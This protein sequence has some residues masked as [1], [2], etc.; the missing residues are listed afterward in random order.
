MQFQSCCLIDFSNIFQASCSSFISNEATSSHSP[1]SDRGHGS[2]IGYP[3]SVQDFSDMYSTVDKS[4][5]SSAPPLV[6]EFI[7]PVN[8]MMEELYAKV[9][10]TSNRNVVEEWPGARPKHSLTGG[11]QTKRHSWASNHKVS[12]SDSENA[13]ERSANDE[14]EMGNEPLHSSPKW[15]NHLNSGNPD[16][17][18][19]GGDG[20]ADRRS[21][22]SESYFQG[23]KFANSIANDLVTPAESPYCTYE[24]VHRK[25][26]FDDE[27]S[28]PGYEKVTQGHGLDDESADPGYEMVTNRNFQVVDPNYESIHYSNV[29]EARNLDRQDESSYW[30]IPL[31]V[32]NIDPLYERINS[33][34]D[35]STDPNYEKVKTGSE[36]SF[37]TSEPGYERVKQHNLSE[38]GYGYQK[39]KDATDMLTTESCDPG[40]EMIQSNI[41]ELHV[42]WYGN[43]ASESDGAGAT[44]HQS[45][46]LQEVYSDPILK[47]TNP[48]ENRVN[49]KFR[50]EVSD[51]ESIETV[52]SFHEPNNPSSSY[53]S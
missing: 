30:Q 14:R 12:S 50:N 39:V 25:A 47:N 19:L 20:N 2:W 28:E 33:Q 15:S 13:L 9:R 7:P 31:R 53:K 26:G 1:V 46:D 40:Y 37:E 32:G 6:L 51:L 17:R 45:F 27:E 49:D 22:P 8:E 18:L 29:S 36:L 23:R 52:S 38:D 41:V 43:D 42:K 44:T 35:D 11:S 16:G 3:R 48:E 24:L 34:E 21:P 4:K 10:K 5:K